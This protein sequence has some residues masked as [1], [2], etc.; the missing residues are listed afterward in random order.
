[1]RIRPSTAAFT[2]N[3]DAGHGPIQVPHAGPVVINGTSSSCAQGYF[4]SVQLSDANWN[5]YGTEF[6]GWLTATDFAQHGPIGSFDVKGFAASRGLTLTQGQYYRVKLAV[7]TPW[8]EASKL[9][10]IIP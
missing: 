5:R 1:V 6:M 7:G 8:S 4:V 9:I 2:L 3:G 10:Q